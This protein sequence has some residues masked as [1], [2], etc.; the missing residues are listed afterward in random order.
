MAA[1]TGARASTARTQVFQS[2]SFS[3]NPSV[4]PSPSEPGVTIAVAPAS[5]I[6]RACRATNSWSMLRS[7]LNAVVMAG[8]TPAHWTLCIRLSTRATSARDRRPAGSWPQREG[9]Y[10]RAGG[11]GDVLLAV[12]D[13]G[14]R[15]PADRPAGLVVPERLA[16]AGVERKDVALGVPRED[17]PASHAQQTALR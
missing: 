2:A 6:Q 10:R 14:D 5:T 15:G 8:M 11:D 13:V 9:E 17:E 1:T 16:G 12:H 7:S 4:A 3:S